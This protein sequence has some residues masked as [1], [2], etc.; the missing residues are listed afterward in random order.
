[1]D[2][3]Y[4]TSA[5]MAHATLTA[6]L[7]PLENRKI[8]SDDDKPITKITPP[9]AHHLIF[10]A[11]FV[12]FFSFAG[13]APYSPAKA[14]LR[15]L[16]DTLSQEMN[17][18][19]A[20]YPNAPPVKLHT[21]FPATILTEAYE[22]ENRIKHGLTKQ[23][24]EGD[25]GQT[26]HLIAS[27]SIKGLEAGQELITTDLLTGLVKGSM[28]G[29][30]VRGGFGSAIL[31]WILAGLMGLV[32]VFVRHDMDTKARAWGKKFGVREMKQNGA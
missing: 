14:A 27:K 17:L 24:E 9:K 29:G 30:S 2:S 4:F 18:Y 15:S 19:A 31:Q 10:T 23:L 3:N 32:M 13:Y 21:I 26:P 11:S 25:D 8:T 28:L 20:S 16:S 22:A 1:M 6:W 7:K 12:S 5:Y